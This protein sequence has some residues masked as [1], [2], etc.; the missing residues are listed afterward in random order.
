[1][2]FRN[3]LKMLKVAAGLPLDKLHEQ[4]FAGPLSSRAS[5]VLGPISRY[6]I[7]DILP[8]PLVLGSLLVS[9]ASFVM[10]CAPLKEEIDHTCI[11]LDAQM[12]LPLSL[13]TMSVPGCITSI[14]LETCYDIATKRSFLT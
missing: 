12:S 13:I 7:A 10:G 8:V 4:D 3:I 11:V 2:K 1:M 6:R 5:K 14:F 9:Y